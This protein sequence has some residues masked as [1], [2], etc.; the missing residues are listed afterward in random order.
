[1]CNKNVGKKREGNG[2]NDKIDEI[3]SLFLCERIMIMIS[4]RYN[5]ASWNESG[6]MIIY[7]L[8]KMKL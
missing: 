2:K 3:S 7:L 8:V 6:S 4:Y 1:M 5:I